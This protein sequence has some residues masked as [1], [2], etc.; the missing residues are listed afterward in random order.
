MSKI[1]LDAGLVIEHSKTKLFH[2]MRV[3]Y[4]PNPSI[5]LLFVEGPVISSKPI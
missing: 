3:Q 1:L 4:P 2:F 5:N